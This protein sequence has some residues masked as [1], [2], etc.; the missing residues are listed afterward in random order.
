[1]PGGARPGAGRPKGRITS[2]SAKAREAAAQTGLLPH[3][4][5]LKVSRGE[6]IEQ[7]RWQVVFDS[8]GREVARELVVEEYYADFSTRVDAAKAA[9]PFYA[10]KLAAQTMTVGMSGT[11]GLHNLSEE[12]LNAKLI[13]L[14]AEVAASTATTKKEA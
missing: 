10:P 1:M 7:K 11:M 5:L 13:L 12:E 2:V 9:A 3:E 8:Q 4:W 6:P 14:T